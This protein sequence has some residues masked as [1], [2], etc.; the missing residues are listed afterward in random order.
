MTDI[1]LLFRK[2]HLLELLESYEEGTAPIDY[3]VSTYFRANKALGSKDRAFIAEEVYRLIRWRDL[4]DYFGKTPPSWEDRIEWLSEFDVQSFIDDDV[5]PIHTRLSMPSEL[6]QALVRSWGEEQAKEIALVSNEPA[7]TFIRANLLKTDRDTLFK[8]FISQGY[9]VSKG[10]ESETAICFHRKCNFFILPEFTEGKFEVQDEASQIVA[11]MVQ[12]KLQQQVLDFC[13][14]SGGKT[15]AF[16]PYLKGTGQIFLHD[17]RLHA[18]YEAKK[19]LKR[20][21]IQNAQIVHAKETARLQKLK[22]NM[23]WV[24]VDAPCTGTGTL[25]RNPDMKYKFSESMLTRLV[26]EQKV[27][28]EQALSYVKPG[29]MIVYA[30]CSI[31]KEENEKQ[32]AH[33]LATYPIELVGSP[34]QSVPAIGKKDGFFAST[35]RKIAAP[36]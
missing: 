19:R 28:F 11:Q 2:K 29:G 22:K 17:V 30:T 36:K 21:G 12:P 3:H 15:L 25:R 18:L 5:I 13:A 6:Y 23:D 1:H 10:L 7:P 24:L 32:V 33:F 27:I 4:I 35:F 26:S 8:E 20:A 9:E 16:A 31:L 14:G 34:F